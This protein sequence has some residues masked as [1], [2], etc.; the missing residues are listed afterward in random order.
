MKKMFV[1][2]D[3]GTT[4]QCRGAVEIELPYFGEYDVRENWTTESVM[5]RARDIL[6]SIDIIPLNIDGWISQN[7]NLLCQFDIESIQKEGFHEVA[8]SELPHGSCGPCGSSETYDDN[9]KNISAL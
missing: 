6:K 9:G 4:P 1:H 7:E 3:D 8:Y 2:C 5:G